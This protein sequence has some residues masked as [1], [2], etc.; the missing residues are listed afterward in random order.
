MILKRTRV[1]INQAVIIA[2]MSAGIP[3]II[4]SYHGWLLNH[5]MSIFIPIAYPKVSKRGNR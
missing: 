3:M 4:C 2:I 5:L 1:T